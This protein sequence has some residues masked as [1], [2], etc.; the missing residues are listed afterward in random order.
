MRRLQRGESVPTAEA[1]LEALCSLY[2]EP[3][4]RYLRALGCPEE[5]SADVTQEFFASF[6]RKGGFQRADP[7]LAK[8][9][10]FIKLAAGHFLANHWRKRAAL[11]R[12]GGMA[13]ENLDE[14]PEPAGEPTHEAGLAY[15][16][17]WAEAVL[18]RALCNVAAEYTARGRRPVFDAVKCGLLRSGGIPDPARTAADLGISESQVRLAVHRARQRLVDALRA[19]VAL[20]VETPAEVEDEMR[21]LIEIIAR[22]R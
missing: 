5:E 11:K 12:G 15:D 3:V 4:R 13:L 16:R 20:T 8:L 17:E 2:W 18:D 22:T 7:A 14:I 9:R 6:L 19:E 21:Y 1:A 10:T